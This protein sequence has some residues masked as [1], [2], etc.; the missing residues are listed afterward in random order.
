M[1]IEQAVGSE[2]LAEQLGR[3]SQSTSGSAAHLAPASAGHR[4]APHPMADGGGTRMPGN[5]GAIARRRP[6]SGA[7]RTRRAAPR[8]SLSE[9]SG[10][11]WRAGPARRRRVAGDRTE[12]GDDAQRPGAPRT[13]EEPGQPDPVLG[14]LQA[15]DAAEV[16]R[17]P[18]RAGDVGPDLQRRQAG[19]DRGRRP[20][21]RPA[22]HPGDVP[23][24]RRAAEDRVGA[25][26]VVAEAGGHVRVADHDRSG[27]PQPRRDGAV[28]V[29]QP[30][31]GVESDRGAETGDV[32]PVFTS[33]HAVQG[34]ERRTGGGWTQRR[35]GRPL[36]PAREPGRCRGRPR[37]LSSPLRASMRARWRRAPRSP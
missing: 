22:R 17:E 7:D 15:V 36:P 13:G 23:R 4:P 27:P 29:G 30:V 34:P 14:G 28:H 24:V 3:A 26:G 21:A 37:R 11:R 2:K 10:R 25:L 12:T 16:G 6:S 19:G 9:P 8:T 35:R 33:S 20:T 1:R 18:D 5:V 31:E 32:V